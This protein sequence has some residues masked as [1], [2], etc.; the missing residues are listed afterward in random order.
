V[1]ELT[2]QQLATW[3]NFY[4]IVGSSGAALVG[5]HNAWDT[6]TYIVIDQPRAHSKKK[7]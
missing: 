2:N 7:E 3:G 5:I 1:T 6:V 4:M